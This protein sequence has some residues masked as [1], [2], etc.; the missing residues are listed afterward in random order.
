MESKY[1]VYILIDSLVHG[2]AERIT[3]ALSQYLVNSGIETTVVTFHSAGRD[4]F[5]L[6]AGVKRIE[7]DLV[8]G[9]GI[10]NKI[11]INVRRVLAVRSVLKRGNADVIIGMMT[12]ASVI[13]LLSGALAGVKTV[14][15]ER[16]F[17]GSKKVAWWW[18]ASRKLLY[19][20]AT[21]HVAQ[22]ENTAEWLRKETGS[23]DV[24]VI[25]NPVIWPLP[26]FEPVV[27]P[28][29]VVPRER[30]C[31]MAA[32]TKIFQ[33]GFDLLVDAYAMIAARC[34]KWDLVVLGV[35]EQDD[36]QRPSL[37]ALRRRIESHRLGDRVY[38]PGP[39]GNMT[40]WYSRADVFVLSSRY[41][42]FPNVLLEAMA[43]G[44]AC[45]A[46]DCDTGPGDLIAHGT[47]G[48]LVARE[49]TAELAGQMERLALD[50]R[51][52]D[53]LGLA[54]RRIREDLAEVRVLEQWR[55]LVDRLAGGEPSPAG[56]RR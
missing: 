2:G 33:K 40:A 24:Q 42:G 8:A 14:I 5:D 38:L 32:G 10:W 30:Q 9:R 27:D 31:F 52:R 7:L 41:E 39:A 3:V 17:P 45:I 26:D 11:R 25:P 15:S 35:S 12:A 28:Y 54:S 20:F 34:T 29:T 36:R 56:C 46:F 43:A 44:R 16:N 18:V 37:E 13:S 23:R 4:F 50:D 19:R 49:N 55:I 48:V 47:N 22:T 51:L 21:A 53:R 1:K 6:G